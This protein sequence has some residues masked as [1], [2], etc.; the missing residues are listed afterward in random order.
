ML[1]DRIRESLLRKA[2][3]N[4][5]QIEEALS[6]ERESG[7]SLD[8]VLVSKNLLPELKCYNSSPSF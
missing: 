4:Q 7:S 5:T 8:Q 3:L 1:Q 6:A 2:G